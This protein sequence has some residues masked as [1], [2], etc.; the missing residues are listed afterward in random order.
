MKKK[1]L[2]ILVLVVVAITTLF[3]CV[4]CSTGIFELDDERDYHQVIATVNYNNMSKEIYKG[5]LYSYV[6]S[7]GASYIQNYGMT[8]EEVVE[9]FYNSLTRNALYTL[10][11]KKYI[12]DNAS[13]FGVTAASSVTE[14]NKKPESFLTLA[15]YVYAVDVSNSDMQSSFDTLYKDIAAEKLKEDEEE[16]TT[17]EEED[18]LVPRDVRTYTEEEASEFNK[19]SKAKCIAVIYGSEYKDITYGEINADLLAKLNVSEEDFKKSITFDKIVEAKI[20]AE[21]D[22]DIKSI[23]KSA[24]KQLFENIEKAYMSV[25]KFLETQIDAVILNKYQSYIS[26]LAKENP[27]AYDAIVEKMYNETKAAA[28]K[29][30]MKESDYSSALEKNTFTLV[31]PSDQYIGVKSILLKFSD[32]QTEALT[33]IKSMYSSD[34]EKIKKIRNNMALGKEDEVVSMLLGENKGILVNVSNPLYDVESGNKAEAYTDKDVDCISLIYAMAD[35][36]ETI[37][38]EIVDKYVASEEYI[39]MDPSKKATALKI[40]EYNAKVEAFTQWIYLV[41]DD[42]GMVG[43]DSYL[44]TPNKKDTSFVEEYTVLARELAKKNEIGATSISSGGSYDTK[45]VSYTGTTPFLKVNGTTANIRALE[46][47][48][49][50]TTDTL[51]STIYTVETATNEI[52]FIIND[53]GIHI[54]MVTK[55][56][57]KD[58][59]GTDCLSYINKDGGDEASF[60]EGGAIVY[61]KNY[62]YDQGCNIKYD[63]TYT[64]VAADATFDANEKYYVWKAGSFEKAE[65]EAFA[66]GVTY[67]TRTWELQ[68]VACDYKTYKDNILDQATSNKSTDLLSEAQIKLLFP[69]FEKDSANKNIVKNEKV[70]DKFVEDL[71]KETK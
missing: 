43:S 18:L 66:S 10:Y 62:V 45:D 15:E 27:S 50:T 41:N 32:K 6:A 54:V 8:I 30:Y 1:L 35:S 49:E 61:N 71:T 12:F 3:T 33:A 56:Y 55:M 14:M 23:I 17:E 48:S 52:S 51:S 28:I 58:I 31:N 13:A 37:A 53:Y 69:E 9:Y 2:A 36:L 22:N 4:S 25:E 11:A 42:P 16:E 26:D 24:K 40:V 70:Y 68:N 47:S 5:Q 63:Y 67:Y 20:K 39:N 60:V 38:K 29:S 44:V 19:K 57:G 59:F 46:C 21:T 64:K 7:Y 65:I 34:P